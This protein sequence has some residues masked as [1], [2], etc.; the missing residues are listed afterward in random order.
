MTKKEKIAIVFGLNGHYYDAIMNSMPEHLTW[1][2]SGEFDA[3]F[4]DWFYSH[5]G[6]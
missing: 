6:L 5:L 3:E 2:D 4:E 1:L